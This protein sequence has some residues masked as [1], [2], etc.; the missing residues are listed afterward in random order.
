VSL[1]T[2]DA[3]SEAVVEA[4]ATPHTPEGL[5]RLLATHWPHAPALQG[6]FALTAAGVALD[7]LF[8]PDHPK[9]AGADVV[10]RAAALLSS[11]AYALN[12]Q[13]KATPSLSEANALCNP[14]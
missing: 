10:F 12:C 1:S 6:A 4:V 7:D 8:T 11:F 9:G 14:P 3:M 13:G 5:V 2:I